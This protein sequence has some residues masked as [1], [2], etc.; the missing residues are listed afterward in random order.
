M[1][2]VSPGRERC[3][4]ACTTALWRWCLLRHFR[5]MVLQILVTYVKQRACERSHPDQM[6]VLSCFGWSMCINMWKRGWNPE[7]SW[8]KKPLAVA[9]VSGYLE[10]VKEI[11]LDPRMVVTDFKRDIS[12]DWRDGP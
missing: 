6:G 11:S 2:M 4:A 10:Q 7:L 9:N 1:G 8:Q 12:C 5:E 3:W